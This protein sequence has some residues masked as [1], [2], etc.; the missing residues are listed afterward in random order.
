MLVLVSEIA[1]ASDEQARGIGQISVAI[2]LMDSGTQNNASNADDCSQES[3]NLRNQAA[4]MN[5]VVER[6]SALV[7]GNVE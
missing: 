7:G 3:A 2:N 6:L 4:E 5:R 1:T